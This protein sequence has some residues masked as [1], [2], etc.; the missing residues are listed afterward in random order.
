MTAREADSGDGGAGTAEPAV[1]VKG[2][3]VTIQGSLVL[4]GVDLTVPRGGVT[5]LL[6]RNGVGKTTTLR[7]LIGLQAGTGDLRIL[8]HATRG[9]PV[10]KIIR[11]GI[12]YVPEDRDVFA[13]LTVAENLRIAQTAQTTA[14]NYDRVYALFPE[15]KVR[16]RQLA[17]TLS[18]GQQQMLAIGRGLMLK[19]QLLLLDEPSLGLSPLLVIEIFRILATLRETGVSILLSEQN[20]RMS[21]AIADRGYVIETGKI[22][23][24]G[25]GA[26][27]L[28]SSDI[29]ER[30]LGVG[31]SSIDL[32]N[33]PAKDELTQKLRAVVGKHAA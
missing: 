10:H 15:L 13:K 5:A 31:A 11:L 18:G 16:H 26:D 21:L 25:T 7:A 29:M 4:Q 9:W 12:G 23:R 32:E 22:V 28:A 14:A 8:G 30:Y 24:E 19:P 6:G 17:G 27:L 3:R 1:D 2:L 20:A 33:D